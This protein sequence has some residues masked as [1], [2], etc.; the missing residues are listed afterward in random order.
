M[1]KLL[2]FIWDN[3]IVVAATGFGLG[4]VV[5]GI[6]RASLTTIVVGLAVAIVSG[7]LAMLGLD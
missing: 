2:I 7:A 4:I 3:L 1:M 5:L 6:A